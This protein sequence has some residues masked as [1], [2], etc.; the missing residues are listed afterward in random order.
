MACLQEHLSIAYAKSLKKAL[1]FHTS[2][3]SLFTTKP[4]IGVGEQHG[5]VQVGTCIGVSGD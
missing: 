3:S 1:W 2:L 5:Q 4:L